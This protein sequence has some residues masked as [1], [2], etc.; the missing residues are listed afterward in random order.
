MPITNDQLG[1]RLGVSHAMASRLRNGKRLPSIRVIDAVHREFGIPVDDLHGAYLE[2]SAA[3]G[4]L[5]RDAIA[6]SAA[7]SVDGRVAA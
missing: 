1:E 3:F 2:G 5:L 4:E 7:P 6:G